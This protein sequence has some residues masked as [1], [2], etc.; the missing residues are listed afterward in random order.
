MTPTSENEHPGKQHS[1]SLERFLCRAG[2]TCPAEAQKRI[3]VSEEN[4][5]FQS[6]LIQTDG[7]RA[8]SPASGHNNN[9]T[10]PICPALSLPTLSN[11]LACEA[12]LLPVPTHDNS[13][14]D[15]YTHANTN[16]VAVLWTPESNTS[17][18]DEILL[19][20][21]RPLSARADGLVWF[22]LV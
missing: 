20:L 22:D 18:R 10:L 2:S 3:S 6:L 1:R 21:F 16:S 5:N 12:I 11:S 19:L 17:T 4:C 13:A 9:T 7:M 8:P 14:T 15:T